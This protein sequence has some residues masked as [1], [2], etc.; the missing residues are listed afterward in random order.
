L[1]VCNA[2]NN[3]ECGPYVIIGHYNATSV[4]NFVRT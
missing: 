3:T 1:S 4:W 2:M